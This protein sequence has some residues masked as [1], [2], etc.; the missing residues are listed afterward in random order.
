MKTIKV[1]T[2]TGDQGTTSLIGGVRVRKSSERIEAYGTVDELNAHLG[3]LTA[4]MKTDDNEMIERIQ[5][6]LFN[7]GAYLATDQSKTPLYESARF[8]VAEVQHLETEI[9]SITDMLPVQSSFILPGGCVEAAQAH[10]CRTVCRRAERCVVSL[11]E[12]IEIEPEILQYFNRIS[13]YLYV[14]ARKLNFI[15]NIGEKKWQ[16]VCK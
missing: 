6:N 9:D 16:N 4:Y 14:L 1:Y 13:D 11:A 5:N 8:N 3:L 7:I 12:T 2:R 10:V 15:N